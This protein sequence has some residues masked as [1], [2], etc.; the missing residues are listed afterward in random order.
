MTG[1]ITSFTIIHI[2]SQGPEASPYAVVVAQA[3]DGAS[4]AAR[5]DGD[6]SWLAIGTPVD[7]VDDGDGAPAQC[8]P[9]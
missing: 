7:I 8:R 6:L 4:R 3:D 9:R 5:A 1:T 2:G